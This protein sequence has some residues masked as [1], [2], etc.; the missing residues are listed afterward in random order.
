MPEQLQ[1]KRFYV[2]GLVQGVGF[3]FFAERVANRLGLS[4]YVRN[5]G[6]GRVEVYA[7]GVPAQL[8]ALRAELERGPRGASIEA[9]GVE[10][11]AVER[12][13]PSGFFIEHD[14]W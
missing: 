10:D 14:P 6:D 13:R 1:A 5:L 8:Q 11:T 2:S 12:G 3:R 4:G 7:V 9:V